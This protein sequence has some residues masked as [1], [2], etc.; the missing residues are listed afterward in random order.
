MIDL[1]CELCADECNDAGFLN[2]PGFR[3]RVHYTGEWDHN[4]RV[5]TI[6]TCNVKAHAGE[7]EARQHNAT[8]QAAVQS[9]ETEY[10]I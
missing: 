6:K 1:L 8:M 10:L 9:G 3:L 5:H 4:Q 7:N 2:C